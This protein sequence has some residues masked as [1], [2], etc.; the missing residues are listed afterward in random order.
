MDDASFVLECSAIWVRRDEHMQHDIAGTWYNQRGSRLTLQ[1]A[2]GSLSGSFASSVGL[3][4]RGGRE[5]VLVGFVSEQLVSFVAAFPEQGSLTAWVGHAL[6]T[7]EESTLELHWQMT[8]ALP[9]TE[10][11]SELWRGIWTGFDV[12]R[13]HPPVDVAAPYIAPHRLPDWP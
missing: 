12:F 3:R 4:K 8:V 11:P 7:G 13:R 6:G 10:D 5:A 9:G 2:N 1:A